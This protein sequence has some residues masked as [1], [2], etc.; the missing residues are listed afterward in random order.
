MHDKGGQ[1]GM[2]YLPRC[3][4]NFAYG[5]TAILLE[6]SWARQQLLHALKAAKVLAKSDVCPAVG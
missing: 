4:A 2:G 3:G 1:Q 5:G 6:A